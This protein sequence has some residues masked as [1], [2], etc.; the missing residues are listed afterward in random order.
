MKKIIDRIKKFFF[1]PAG[2]PRWVRILPYAILGVLT[3]VVFILGGA[4]FIVG[5]FYL[6]DYIRKARE[7]R[8]LLAEPGKSKFIQNQD[9]IEE[10]AWRLGSK[11]EVIVVD[12]KKELKIRQHTPRRGFHKKHTSVFS[13]APAHGTGNSPCI[14]QGFISNLATEKTQTIFYSQ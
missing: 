6:L 9:R 4:A 12:K 1:P 10:L 3:L 7:L 14:A 11:F 2:S 8:K 13:R 5:A